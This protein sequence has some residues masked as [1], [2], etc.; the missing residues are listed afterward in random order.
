MP[1]MLTFVML[2]AMTFLICTFGV[3]AARSTIDWVPAASRSSPL[4]TL[5][6]TP[7][8]SAR[9]SR[10]W[11]V[12]TMSPRAVPDAFASGASGPVCCAEAVVAKTELVIAKASHPAPRNWSLNMNFLPLEVDIWIAFE[13][14]G[15]R[16]GI[17]ALAVPQARP[18]DRLRS[19]EHTSELQS[20]MRISYA[21][22]CL[23]KKKI[24]EQ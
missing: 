4:S 18:H 3:T 16:P 7:T 11:A 15:L 10:R 24:I 23:K 1:R 22:F 6:V 5:I 8:S 2:L 9:C 17:G 13:C 21:V 14:L 19:E 20:L 12:T